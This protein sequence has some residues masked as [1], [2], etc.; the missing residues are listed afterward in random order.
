MPEGIIGTA[1]IMFGSLLIGAI[2]FGGE[3]KWKLKRLT[4][5]N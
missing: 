1:A 4:L 2:I 5:T 3:K